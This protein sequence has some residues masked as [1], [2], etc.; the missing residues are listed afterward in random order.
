MSLMQENRVKIGFLLTK[1]E[2]RENFDLG[3]NKVHQ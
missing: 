1:N 3:E 2:Y